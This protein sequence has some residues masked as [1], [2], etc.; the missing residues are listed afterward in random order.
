M[1]IDSHVHLNNPKYKGE[2]DAIIA[3]FER[4]GLIAAI[5]VGFDRASSEE[6][7]ALAD[8][9]Q[10]IYASVGVH[11]HDAKTATVRDYDFFST[12]AKEPKVVAIGEAGLDYYYE[13]SDRATQKRVF[14][15]QLELAHALDLPVIIHLRDAYGDAEKLLKDNKRYLARGG[16]L[17]CFGG[18]A[19]FLREMLKLN[20]YVS[21]GG[22]ITFKNAA[23]RLDALRATPLERLLVETD[24]PY[25]TPEPHRGKL[26]YPAYIVHV[27]KR[28]AEALGKSFEEVRAATVSNTKTLFRL[29]I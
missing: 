26:N 28:A 3:G 10:R 20:L 11:P 15:E 7:L 4:D 24:C 17:H 1:L 18:S 2:A 6:T 27:A 23:S 12:A 16:V 5:N 13:L 8:K 29:P 14:A 22:A 19:E 9:H 25:L 21:Y